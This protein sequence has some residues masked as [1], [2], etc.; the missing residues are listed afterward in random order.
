MCDWEHFDLTAHAYRK[1]L[2][3]LVRQISPKTVI[4]AHGS[5]P[6]KDWFAQ[7]IQT[8]HPEIQTI[9]IKSGEF[10]TL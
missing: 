2:L 6:S 1:E 5:T 9:D 3:E 8:N 4:L 7:Q 10:V